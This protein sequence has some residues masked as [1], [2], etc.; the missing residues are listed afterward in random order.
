MEHAVRPF[1][2]ASILRII[3]LS[4]CVVC[5][6]KYF[7]VAV[8][9]NHSIILVGGRNP[10]EI[11]N[12]VWVYNI[13]EKSW[14]EVRVWRRAGVVVSFEVSRRFVGVWGCVCVGGWRM[15]VS[16]AGGIAVVPVFPHAVPQ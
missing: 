1:A 13:A 15:Y 10:F 16:A 4:C 14:N 2:G 7:G 9:G 3:R 5:C 8:L 12:D 6:S 11:F